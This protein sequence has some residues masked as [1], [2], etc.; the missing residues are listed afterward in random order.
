MKKL[1]VLFYILGGLVI[2]AIFKLPS[3]LDGLD[4]GF[5]KECPVQITGVSTSGE[6]LIGRVVTL[7]VEIQSNKNE[8][9]AALNIELPYG[10]ELVKGNLI[11]KGALSA[12]QTKAHEVSVRVLDEGNWPITLQARTWQSKN[13]KEV[14][15][16]FTKRIYF[17]TTAN[18]AKVIH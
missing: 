3:L 16:I 13:H 2:L 8:P 4:F 14:T 11:W 5:K 1:T 9:Y 6:P 17:K 7:R 12:G 18:S 15:G 10:V